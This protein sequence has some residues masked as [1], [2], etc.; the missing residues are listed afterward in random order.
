MHWRKLNEWSR[1]DFK[2]G[3]F[4]QRDEM[5]LAVPPDETIRMYCLLSLEEVWVEFESKEHQEE[6]HQEGLTTEE[7]NR[8]LSPKEVQHLLLEGAVDIVVR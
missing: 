2:F 5:H 1:F 3:P 7:D 4:K 8:R 6:L